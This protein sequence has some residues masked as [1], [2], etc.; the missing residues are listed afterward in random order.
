MDTSDQIAHEGIVT[1]FVGS[2]A[3]IQ[4][5]QPGAC[6]SCD[7]KGFCGVEDEDRSRFE[8]SVSGLKIGDHVN[9]DISPAHG[10]KAM[11]WAYFFP[12]ILMFTVIAMGTAL[13]YS[14]GLLGAAALLLLVPYYVL[15]AVFKKYLT[16]QIH[17]H[18]EKL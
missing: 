12:F 3:V 10:F 11:F 18:V 15:L 5:I 16:Q 2:K 14:E 7:I 9:V 1:S 6:H 13:G 8:V 4:L 17:L